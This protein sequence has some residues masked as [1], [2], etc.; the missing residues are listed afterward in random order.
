MKI[1]VIVM[2]L[3]ALLLW[4][5]EAGVGAAEKGLS[6]DEQATELS[7]GVTTE[8]LSLGVTTDYLL[9]PEDVLDITVW[10]S[11]DLSKVVTVRPDGKISLPLI[12]DVSAMGKT[13]SQLAGDISAKLKEYKEN[14][15]VSIVVKE[16]NS[17]AIYVLGEV[18][19]PGK[20]PLKIK[21]TLLQAITL[22]SGLTS[23]AARNKIVVFRF[24]KDG[25]Q[26]KIKASYDDIVLRDGTVQNIELRRGDQIVV[27]SENM[28]LTP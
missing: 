15:Q 9:G 23:T 10:R 26:I 16:V 28:V 14:P 7:L 17:Y 25:Q 12:G 6:P 13:A 3:G 24:G 8:R 27:P 5:Q 20:Y 22:A 1:Q 18:T 2:A 21:T 19:K 4:Q 11:A